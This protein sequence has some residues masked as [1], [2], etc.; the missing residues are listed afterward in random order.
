MTMTSRLPVVAVLAL[1]P[2]LLAGCSDN[3]AQNCPPLTHPPV[4]TVAAAT[5]PCQ[6]RAGESPPLL[7][8]RVV[9]VY[10]RTTPPTPEAPTKYPLRCG[11]KD[12]GYLHLL[13]ELRQGNTDHGDPAN[14]PAFDAQVAYTVEHGSPFVQNNNNVRLTAK[15][16]EAQQ[17]CHNGIW[18][19]R[20]ILATNAPPFP[21]PGWRP[22]GLPVGII[23]AYRLPTQP[24]S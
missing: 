10:Q 23:T 4:L 17:K 20:V 19:F 11:N 18:G 24:S 21:P 13:D 5:N 22:D 9:R 7:A 8:Q 14:D 3:L 6:A 1:A 16:N 2:L 15:Y 12:Y